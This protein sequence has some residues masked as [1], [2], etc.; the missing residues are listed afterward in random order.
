MKVPAVIDDNVIGTYTVEEIEARLLFCEVEHNL[1]TYPMPEPYTTLG[2]Y[3]TLK[4][5]DVN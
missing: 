1:L 3:Q 4:G 2:A 5:Y